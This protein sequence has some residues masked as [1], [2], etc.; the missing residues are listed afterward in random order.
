MSVCHPHVGASL[1]LSKYQLDSSNIECSVSALLFK[2]TISREGM[3]RT[4][5]RHGNQVGVL[6]CNVQVTS[7]EVKEARSA[8]W[9]I[10][11]E[12]EERGDNRDT[13]WS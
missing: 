7:R 11:W 3:Y 13:Q 5:C 1:V 12:T 4:I 8:F 2:K 10:V 9:S 6:L